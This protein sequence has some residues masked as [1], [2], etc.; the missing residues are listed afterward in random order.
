MSHTG[1]DSLGAGNTGDG[2]TVS[3]LEKVNGR[4]ECM[5]RVLWL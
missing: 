2:V 3:V 5:E 1:S 4:A